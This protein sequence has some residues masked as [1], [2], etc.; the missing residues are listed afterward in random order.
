MSYDDGFHLQIY[1]AT[2]V[3]VVVLKLLDMFFDR[4]KNI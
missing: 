1:I 3:L 4:N 2:I